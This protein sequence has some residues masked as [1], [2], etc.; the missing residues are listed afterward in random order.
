MNRPDPRSTPCGQARQA[1]RLQK[2]TQFLD[3]AATINVIAE[4]PDQYPDAV[5]TLY[6]HAGIAAAD[7]ICCARLGKHASGDGHDDAVRLVKQIDPRAAKNLATL[8]GMKARSG[9]SS[10]TSPPADWRRAERA[11]AALV[12]AARDI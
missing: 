5:I 12:A 1:G 7:V 9:Y 8:L 4:R 11:A 10:A 3:A 6:V 2:A